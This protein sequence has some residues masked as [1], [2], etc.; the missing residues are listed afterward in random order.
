MTSSSLF[1]ALVL[2][3][4]ICAVTCSPPVGAQ[5]I[6]WRGKL[7]AF[8]EA[9]DQL[10]TPVAAAVEAWL[11]FADAQGYRLLVD[12][13]QDVILLLHGGHA[14]TQS[15]RERPSVER[16]LVALDAARKIAAPLL[17]SAADD[18]PPAVLVGT[19]EEDYVPLLDHVARIEPRIAGWAKARASQVAGFVLSEPLVAA[20]LDDGRGQEEWD[21]RH[22][23]AHRAAQLLL[24]R[25]APQ[26]PPWVALGFGW[27]VEEAV[28]GA[29][30]CFPHR[31]GFVWAAEHTG[32]ANRLKAAF[33]PS[34]RR[35]KEL[36]ATLAIEEIAAWDPMHDETGF[37]AE[38][39]LIAFGL[40]R[41]LGVVGQNEAAAAF[42]GFDAAIRSGWRVQLSET[43]WT[44]D[45]EYR[46]PPAQ[47]EAVLDG[48]QADFL[49]R[50]T[51]AFAKGRLPRPAAPGSRKR[52]P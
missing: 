12:E 41:Y 50:A 52:R 51:E 31:A 19:V 27:H 35:S 32:W 17:P 9:R 30:Y 1:R 29:I 42:G 43:E 2:A 16:F 18:A 8:G 22:E 40:V 21:T 11:P 45:P 26:Q 4:S 23:L 38:R 48:A 6:T 25:A 10:T 46:L 39:A 37:D 33:Q 36:P 44:T 24:R 15:R 3:V 7:V 28:L 13:D 49:T 20:W 5:E 34:R 47:Q 14:R